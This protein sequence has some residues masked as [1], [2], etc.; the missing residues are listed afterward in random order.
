MLTAGIAL[1]ARLVLAAVI[2]VA[3]IAKLRDRAGTRTSLADFGVPRRL[4]GPGGVLLPLLE[5]LV[6]ASLLRPATAA[7]GA[8]AAVLLLGVF[9]L[10]I[11]VNL[12]RGHAPR[13]HCFG[14]LRSAPTSWKTVARNLVLIGLGVLS[15]VGAGADRVP[16]MVGSAPRGTASRGAVSAGVALGLAALGG[17]LFARA[18]R[19]RGRRAWRL[20][21]AGSRRAPAGSGPPVVPAGHGLSPGAPAPAF[22]ATDATSGRRVTRDDLL[23]SRRPLLLVFTSRD[24]HACRAFLPELA[25]WQRTSPERLTIAVASDG[26]AEVAGAV[27]REFGLAHVLVDQD[28]ALYHAY[29]GYGTPS[30]VLVQPD[31]TVGSRVAAG[32]DAITE[33]LARLLRGELEAHRCRG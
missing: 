12:V 14:Q 18:M 31:A 9:S 33:L 17:L 3:A 30:A 21:A 24:C 11:A 28:L 25:R 20:D 23:A 27:A 19:A 22:S 26:D 1:A 8:A 7:A 16:D 2:A 6:A 10:A 32:S 15:W 29:R 4:A 5:L 13:C